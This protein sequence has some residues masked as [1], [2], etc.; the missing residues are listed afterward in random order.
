[1]LVGSGFPHEAEIASEER[2]ETRTMVMYRSQ[3][4][5]ELFLLL[6]LA[7]F[8]AE[9]SPHVSDL[10]VL[11]IVRCRSRVGYTGLGRDEAIHIVSAL[12][13]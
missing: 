12:Y 13:V 6:L 11:G 2:S 5:D 8:L 10:H 9:S 7:I 4:R 1:M 3:R